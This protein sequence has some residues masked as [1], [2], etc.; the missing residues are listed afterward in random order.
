[1]ASTKLRIG[2]VGAGRRGR[3]HLATIRELPDLFEL[4]GVCDSSGD[5]AEALALKA[6]VKAYTDVSEFIARE[7][8]DAIVIATPPETHH[9][10]ARAAAERGVHLLIETPLGTT[11]AMM[12]A[13]AEIVAKTG[14]VAEI[15]ENMWRRPTERLNRMAIDAGLIGKVMR[16]NSFYEDSGHD[17]CYHTM[18]RFRYYAG[19]EVEEVHAT[20]RRYDLDPGVTTPAGPIPEGPYRTEV[21]HEETWTHALVYFTNGVVGSCTYITKWNRPLRWA[22]PHFVS[23]EGNAGYIA[24]SPGD[25]NV[26]RRVEGGVPLTYERKVEVG[27]EPGHEI[28]TRYSYDTEPAVSYENPFADRPLTDARPAG[29]A[30]GIARAHEL[31]CLHDSVTG[32]KP[33]QYT[34]E[35]ARRDQEL[36]IAI[37]ESGRT[38]RPVRQLAGDETPWERDQREAFRRLT[39]YDP[40]EGA[41]FTSGGGR[42]AAGNC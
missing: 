17:S 7:Q 19:A 13:T 12:D 35:Q 23:I 5:M 15:G 21:L 24:T 26:L 6:A 27:G 30:D 29:H 33:P 41:P 11:R 32:G 37:A 8:V 39:G 31:R 42:S 18:S 40:L 36:S 22:H 20:V 10:V 9:I 16:V 3:A 1:M 14:V 28:P 38:G 4:V 34:I 25:T 2:V